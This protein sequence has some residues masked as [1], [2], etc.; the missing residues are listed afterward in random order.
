MTKVCDQ[1]AVERHVEDGM[2]ST[3]TQVSLQNS[4][5]VDSSPRNTRTGLN[6]S[7]GVF[8]AL[9]T[10]AAGTMPSFSLEGLEYPVI[11][12]T[13]L[14]EAACGD[15]DFMVVLLIWISINCTGCNMYTLSRMI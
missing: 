8:L 7:D 6:G 4:F 15:V 5:V 14:L 12:E 1:K 3:I 13:I 11:D 10:D 9:N 2:N